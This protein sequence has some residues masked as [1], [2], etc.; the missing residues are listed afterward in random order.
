MEFKRSKPERRQDRRICPSC[1]TP[2]AGHRECTKCGAKTEARI[3]V[4]WWV[5]GKRHRELTQFWREEDA[6]AFLQRKEADYWRQQDLGVERDIGGSFRD[7]YKAFM[8]SRRQTSKHYQKQL[9]TALNTLAGGFGWDTCVTL[10]SARDITQYREEGLLSLSPSTVRSYMVGIRQFTKYL[11]EEGWIRRDPALKVKLPAARKG[12]DHLRPDEVGK[13]L[14]AFWVHAPDHAAIATALILGG[15]RKGEIVNLRRQDTNLDTR[16][17]YVLDF[18]G[19]ELTEA[20]S[21]KTESSRRAVPLHPLVAEAL[22]RVEPVECPDG[23]VSPWV[24]PVID[25]RKLKRYRDKQ[26]RSNPVR[27]DRRSPETAFI[28]VKLRQVLDIVGIKR[29]V[30]IHGLRRTFAI[31]LQEAGA[32]DAAIR[33]ALGHSARGVTECH[34]LPRRDETVKRWVD[35]IDVSIPALESADTDQS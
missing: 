10:L 18:E 14:Q 24:F 31:L 5:D 27:G 23:T 30:T 35:A 20:W 26:G 11:A 7:G 34:Y 32:P 21:P 3:R 33:Q 22:R 28:A 4:V 19:D 2:N 16:W 9:R 1:Q 29:R 15:W 12:H 8:A 13:V 25:R 6:N 17:A